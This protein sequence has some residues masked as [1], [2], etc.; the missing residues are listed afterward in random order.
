MPTV[1]RKRAAALNGPGS[2]AEDCAGSVLAAGMLAEG[3][4][5]GRLGALTTLMVTP[6]F[7]EV[8]SD[9]ADEAGWREVDDTVH[10]MEIATAEALAE[11]VVE[12]CQ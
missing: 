7:A 6:F 8:L 4:A 2:D 9:W 1:D 11:A 5:E 3:L 12:A 10:A